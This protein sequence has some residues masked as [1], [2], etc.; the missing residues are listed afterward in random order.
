MV[1][2][3][4]G[5]G[6]FGFV[7]VE[8]IR[9]SYRNVDRFCGVIIADPVAIHNFFREIEFNSGS[10]LFQIFPTKSLSALIACS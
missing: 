7:K 9:V 3:L 10:S 1:T 2:R 6:V 8:L 5:R 4:K